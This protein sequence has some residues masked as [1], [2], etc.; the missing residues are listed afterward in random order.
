MFGSSKICFKSGRN[1]ISWSGLKTLKWL[2]NTI[3]MNQ[4]W[5][6]KE[7]ITGLTQM[8]IASNCLD[9]LTQRSGTLL[10]DATSN[11]PITG[12]KDLYCS[13][14]GPS[15][16][17]L[18]ET[19]NACPA[20]NVLPLQVILTLNKGR[21]HLAINKQP[22]SLLSVIEMINLHLTGDVGFRFFKFVD[23]RV[24]LYFVIIQASP[25]QLQL[26]KYR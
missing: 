12:P 18:T 24:V 7:S 11:Y 8:I 15:L 6:I 9:A 19:T 13:R 20:Y 23:L 17:S 2:Q 26:L 22:V 5:A 1:V 3:I 10:S 25:C 14:D 16:C 4:G 21:L